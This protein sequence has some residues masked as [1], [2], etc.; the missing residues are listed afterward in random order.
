MKT[1]GNLVSSA[2]EFAARMKNREDDLHRAD[3]LFL[4]YFHRNAAA[5]VANGHGAVLVDED[6][7]LRAGA[8]QRLVHRIVHNLVHQM[9]QT[10]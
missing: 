4:I 9:V 8:R 3:A 6:I 5:V 1:A 10:S 7:D 2:A